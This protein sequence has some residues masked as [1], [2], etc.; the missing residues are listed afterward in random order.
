MRGASVAVVTRSAVYALPWPCAEPPGP[1][2]YEA[3]Y[4]AE[5]VRFLAAGRSFDVVAGEC[6]AV[7][8]LRPGTSNAL[9]G[10]IEQPIECMLV[11]QEDPPELL[12]GTVDARLYRLVG[13]TARRVE[14]FHALEC[15]SE[16]HTPW[17]GPPSVRSL[18]ATMDGWVYADIHVG[19][20]MR[21][22]DRGENWQPVTPELHEDVHQVATTPAAPDRVYA[23]T[24]AGVYVSEDRGE[25]WHHRAEDLGCRYGRAMAPSPED[26]DLLLATV[27]DGPHGDDVHGQLWRSEDCGRSWTHVCG[28][29]PDS[30]PENINTHHVVFSPGG[31]AWALAGGAVYAGHER[32]TRWEQVW[33]PPEPPLMLAAPLAG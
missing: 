3:R 28:G 20:I 9:V 4:E 17:G 25:T 13:G 29:F 33:Q 14:S 10:G 5:G 31:P 30:T 23:N 24:A 22:S 21:S 8:F 7:C 12:V 11:L 1:R 2:T 15:R 19:S 32:A 16:W 6:G 26:P 27:S 18:A